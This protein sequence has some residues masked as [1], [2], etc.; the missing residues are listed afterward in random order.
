MSIL[1]VGGAAALFFTDLTEALAE[2]RHAAEAQS[3]AEVGE[4]ISAMAHELKS[5]LATVALYTNLLRRTLADKPVAVEQLDVI[6]DQTRRCLERIRAIMHSIN[7]DPARVSG[8]ALTPLQ[9]LVRAVVNDQLRRYAGSVITLECAFGDPRVTLGAN[10]LRSLVSN[11]VV[12]ALE[13][14]AGK[15]PVDVRL[16][17]DAGRVHLRVAD[18]GPGLPAGDLFAAI[19]STKSSGSGLGLWLVRRLAEEAGGSISARDRRGAGA[20]FEVELPLP[21]RARPRGAEL[22]E[23]ADEGAPWR[24]RR[25]ERPS[26]WLARVGLALLDYQLPAVS[27]VEIAARLPAR[28]PIFALSADPA[29]GAALADVGAR[30]ASCLP[31]PCAAA[32]SLDLACLL[33]GSP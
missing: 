8:T 30:R 1:G 4:I 24:R 14:T 23:V 32:N 28:T 21:R 17:S 29:A 11:L 10:E 26:D 19:F 6:K 27:G 25:Q 18:T 31:K 13:M 7:P 20:V 16:W 9:P 12:N 15:G 33:A 22:L 3:F 2:E 5:P